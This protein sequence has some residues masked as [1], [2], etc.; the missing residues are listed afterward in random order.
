MPW[1]PFHKRYQQDIIEN[2]STNNNCR[3]WEAKT[4]P[5]KNIPQETPKEIILKSGQLLNNL[6]S[7]EKYQRQYI[8]KNSLPISQRSSKGIENWPV[9]MVNKPGLIN[10]NSGT[11]TRSL[12]ICFTSSKT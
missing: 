2:L 11:I 7:M 10:Q 4:A 5:Q 3:L 1:N 12:T 9:N 6:A 8:S